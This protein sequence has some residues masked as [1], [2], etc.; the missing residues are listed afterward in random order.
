MNYK[1]VI[2]AILAG[3]LL[4]FSL[5]PRPKSPNFDLSWPLKSNHLDSL[6]NALIH[7]E[8]SL[9]LYEGCEANIVW[10][11]TTIKR[12]TWVLL[13][14]PGFSANHPEG[15]PTHL[16]LAQKFGMNAYLA[17]NFDH[18]LRRDSALSH[19]SAEQY[20]EKVKE[21]LA[22]AEKLGDHVIIMSTSTGGSAALKLAAEFPDKVAGLV[23]YS[24]NV[25][26][27]DPKSSLLLAPWG[28]Q[29]AES[30]IGPV[31]HIESN[32][33]D[34]AKYWYLDYQTSSLVELQNFLMNALDER[35]FAKINC[36]VFIAAYDDGKGNSD[37]VVSVEA[38]EWMYAHLR[39]SVK[40][41][42][43][44]DAGNHIIANPL[45]SSKTAEIEAATSNWIQ[46]TF[47]IV[48]IA[49]EISRP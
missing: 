30:I 11:D 41:F 47:N 29:I 24:P 43:K 32:N 8:K 27:K 12:S 5:G 37:P 16:H 4:I 34:H 35:T 3:I 28:K 42:E 2:F 31:R 46:G 25:R 23:L 15:A 17:R 6:E 26:L 48:P 49:H 44:F 36:P 22:I 21:D 13:Y 38:M 7:S 1:K 10:A 14:L 39:S 20:W 45:F 9:N 40:A 33:P 18:G 19:F